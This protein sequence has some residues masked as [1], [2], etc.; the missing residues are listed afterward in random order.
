MATPP[1]KTNKPFGH[2]E[3]KPLEVGDLVRVLDGTHDPA[4]PAHRTGLVM[5]VVISEAEGARD[6][7]G[8]LYR[9]Q[10]GASILKFHPMFLEKI[11]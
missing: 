10:F 1:T 11:S 7:R 2:L 3:R 9:V 4:M 8:P 5:E 6:L